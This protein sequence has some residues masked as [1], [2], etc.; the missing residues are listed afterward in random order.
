ME[1][2]AGDVFVVCPGC[3]LIKSECDLEFGSLSNGDD[4]FA[5]FSAVT[6]EAIDILGTPVG[7]DPE[8]DS[9]LWNFEATKDQT[10][11]RNCDDFGN[12][13]ILTDAVREHQRQG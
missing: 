5:L 1:I 4:V 2:A 12:N 8:E 3:S 9:P 10:L 6:G 11:V 7:G 13:R